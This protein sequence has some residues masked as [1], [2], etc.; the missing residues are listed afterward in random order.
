MLRPLVTKV[1]DFLACF[2]ESAKERELE[3]LN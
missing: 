2:L 3:N 1:A